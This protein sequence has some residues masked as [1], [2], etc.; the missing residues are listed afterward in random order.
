MNIVTN[1]KPIVS[2]DNDEINKTEPLIDDI[3]ELLIMQETQ[4]K[5]YI[6]LTIKTLSKINELLSDK[7]MNDTAK[8]IIAKHY[9]SHLVESLSEFNDLI[10]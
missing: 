1:D 8:N 10:K 4:Y 9:V 2:T 6:K 7:N 3:I 5:D